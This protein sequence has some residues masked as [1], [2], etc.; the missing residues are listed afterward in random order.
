MLF[1]NFQTIVLY[2]YGLYIHFYIGSVL[3]Y[4]IFTIS[5]LEGKYK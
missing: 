2:V 4:N 3:L 1:I 5:T